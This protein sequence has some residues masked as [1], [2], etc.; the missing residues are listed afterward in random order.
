MRPLSVYILA[1]ILLYLP[2]AWQDAR[3]I[4]GHEKACFYIFN[5]DKCHKIYL[6]VNDISRLLAPIV[7]GAMILLNKRFDLFCALFMVYFSWMLIDH[8]LWFG[9]TE[10]RRY[11]AYLGLAWMAGWGI[12]ETIKA[13]T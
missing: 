1:F 11:V 8:I 7:F 9:R 5:P 4:W 13:K 10:G 2:I 12:Y 3:A 6:I